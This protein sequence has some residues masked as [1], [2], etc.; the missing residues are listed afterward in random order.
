MASAGSGD[1]VKF[2][3]SYFPNSGTI[4]LDSNNKYVT[5]DSAGEMAISASRDT[6]GAWE[7]FVIRKKG[8]AADDVYTIKASSNGKFIAVG[9]DG[10]LVNSAAT[11]SE[12]AGF[13]FVAQS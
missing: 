5:A 8:G 11:E 4:Q 7:R 3:S 12:A 2:R 6:A 10:A 9:S 1:A 13:Q